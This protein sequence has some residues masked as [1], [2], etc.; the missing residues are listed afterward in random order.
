MPRVALVALALLAGAS[1]TSATTVGEQE[2]AKQA[3][4]L[5]ALHKGLSE[6]ALNHAAVHMEPCFG[7]LTQRPRRGPGTSCA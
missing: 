5:V 3:E 4:S 2:W 6:M 1:S 7:Q